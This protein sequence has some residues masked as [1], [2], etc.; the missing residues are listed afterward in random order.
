MLPNRIQQ[1]ITCAKLI[2][3][4]LLSQ[5]VPLTFFGGMIFFKKEKIRIEFYKIGWIFIEGSG[6]G[7]T[8]RGKV[9]YLEELCHT[10]NII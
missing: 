3:K 1:V 7:L 4:T 8:E 6:D 2:F 5:F 9:S 10:S